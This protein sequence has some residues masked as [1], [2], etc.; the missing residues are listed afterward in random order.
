MN[1]FGEILIKL[2]KEK[3]LTQEDLADIFQV[4][5]QSVSKWETNTTFPETEKLVS[6]AKYF[7]VTLDSLINSENRR[8]IELTNTDEIVHNELTNMDSEVILDKENEYLQQNIKAE[9]LFNKKIKKRTYATIII[10]LLI[11][12]IGI[13]FLISKF[14]KKTYAIGDKVNTAKKIQL[15]VNSVN[16]PGNIGAFEP[17]SGLTYLVIEIEMANKDETAITIFPEQFKYANKL[18]TQTSNNGSMIYFYDTSFSS[19]M[20]FKNEIDILYGI[21]LEPNSSR[22]GCLIFASPLDARRNQKLIFTETLDAGNKIL[23]YTIVLP[24]VT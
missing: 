10:L 5:R 11:L 16:Y 19:E 2:R 20:F 4:S 7:N 1:S 24:N 8:D 18:M 15:Q 3:G 21:S 12:I 22:K 9:K 13:P 14:E 6:I 23:V 17:S